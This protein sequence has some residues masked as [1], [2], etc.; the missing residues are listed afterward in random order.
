MN[1]LFKLHR[2]TPRK[3]HLIGELLL[4][5]IEIGGSKDPSTFLDSLNSPLGKALFPSIYTERV[6]PP[7]ADPITYTQISTEDFVK[8]CDEATAAGTDP[9]VHIFRRPCKYPYVSAVKMVCTE[10]ISVFSLMLCLLFYGLLLGWGFALGFLLML[11][12]HEFGHWVIIRRLNLEAAPPVFIPMI[13]AIINM[14][15]RVQNAWDDARIGLGGP[16][17]GTMAAFA[18]ML[19]TA[20]TENHTL[21]QVAEVGVFINLLNLIPMLP[22]DG[23]RIV[24]AI[25]RWIMVPGLLILIAWFVAKPSGLVPLVILFGFL[26]LWIMI[27]KSPIEGYWD[28]KPSQRFITAGVYAALVT[29]LV[30]SY[31]QVN[32]PEDMKPSQAALMFGPYLLHA[33]VSWWKE[34][35]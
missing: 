14:K 32:I 2:L 23:G 31:E 5:W 10:N 22:L 30:I 24:G 25:H 27:K 7:G 20:I 29:I 17:F 19:L 11:S 16:L 6:S 12:A 18:C 26:E 15:S 9:N 35:R 33:L 8:R 21:H 1:L 13:G 34:R 3:F 4:K 28:V